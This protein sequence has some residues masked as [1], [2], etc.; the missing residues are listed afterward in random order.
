MDISLLEIVPV[1]VVVVKCLKRSWTRNN[2]N[3]FKMTTAWD[4]F[5]DLLTIICKVNGLLKQSRKH[6]SSKYKIMFKTAFSKKHQQLH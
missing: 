5:M 6:K 4:P 3:I 2:K 1:G